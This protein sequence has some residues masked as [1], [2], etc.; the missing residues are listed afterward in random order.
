MNNYSPAKKSEQRMSISPMEATKE[1][2]QINNHYTEVDS[3]RA[4]QEV[5][6]AYVMAKKFPRNENHSLLKITESCKRRRM[7]EGAMYSYPKGGKQVS[8]PSIRLAEVMAKSWGNLDYG[9]VEL[10]RDDRRSLVRAYC[11]DLET[12]VTKK[13]DFTVEHFIDTK[14]GPKW[15]S[16]QR[17][18]YELVA[19]QGARRLRNCILA[20]IPEDITEEAMEIC[21]KTLLSSDNNISIGDRIKKMIVAFAE[22]NVTP[23]MMEA[24][25][26][27]KLDATQPSELVTLQK[28]YRSIKDGF[29][30]VPAYFDQTKIDAQKQDNTEESEIL[31][32]PDSLL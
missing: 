32:L 2:T 6:A 13:L 7:A 3:Q 20:I 19:N 11:I 30:T 31:P 27:H 14:K 16:D 10:Q 9:V 26:G 15:L 12:N 24:K 29:A 4:L 25:L 18:V 5:Q 17:D 8:G 1:V 23:A 22:F 21:E 28:I